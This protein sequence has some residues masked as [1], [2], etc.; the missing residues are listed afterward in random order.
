MD[1]PASAL[2]AESRHIVEAM[3]NTLAEEGK[4]VLL[5]SHSDFRP[6]AAYTHVVVRSG[7]VYCE[8]Y[9]ST[10]CTLEPEEEDAAPSPKAQNGS[11]L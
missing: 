7:R 9:D 4:A 8:Q 5:V 2:D 1:E 6:S 3:V 10:M 11:A